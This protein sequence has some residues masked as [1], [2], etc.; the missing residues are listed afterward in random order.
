MTAPAGTAGQ[1][2]QGFI[3][4]AQS[5]GL[6]NIRTVISSVPDGT[7]DFYGEQTPDFGDDRRGFFRGW[8]HGKVNTLQGQQGAVAEQNQRVRDALKE[9]G[10][11][12]LEVA[13][14]GGSLPNFGPVLH[15][16]KNEDWVSLYRALPRLIYTYSEE[17]SHS[18]TETQLRRLDQ[19]LLDTNQYD[20]DV[21]FLT[22]LVYGKGN[23]GQA[24]LFQV[25]RSDNVHPF[26]G[27]H[28]PYATHISLLATAPAVPRKLLEQMS[29]AVTQRIVLRKKNHKTQV[30]RNG[31]GQPDF[32]LNIVQIWSSEAGGRYW[33]VGEGWKR[34]LGVPSRGNRETEGFLATLPQMLALLHLRGSGHEGLT[35][36]PAVWFR[37]DKH[38]QPLTIDDVAANRS[39]LFENDP[40]VM[41]GNQDTDF[42][43]VVLFSK[44]VNWPSESFFWG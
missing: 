39:I 16:L 23:D 22:V 37:D 32:Y 31:P 24:S 28:E 3:P 6:N 33:A 19:L 13:G 17:E 2:G 41:V 10:T 15:L 25:E 14:F 34:A 40:N 5:L 11:P 7:P 20:S 35:S 43:V 12:S 30:T 18:E 21:P 27:G 4:T 26:E 38:G 8:T 36:S 29:D 9:L 44:N 42:K 1:P